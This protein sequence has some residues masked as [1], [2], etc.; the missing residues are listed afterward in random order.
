MQYCSI[1]SAIK[2]IQSQ[3]PVQNMYWELKNDD[4]TRVILVTIPSYSF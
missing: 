1:F 4:K 2:G 3:K